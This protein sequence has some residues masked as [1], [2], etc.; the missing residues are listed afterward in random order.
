[1]S[2]PRCSSCDYEFDECVCADDW[3]EPKDAE[4]A[5]LKAEVERLRNPPKYSPEAMLAFTKEDENRA[6]TEALREVLD[7]LMD[8]CMTIARKYM[9]SKDKAE[10]ETAGMASYAQGLIRCRLKRML[11]QLEAE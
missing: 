7:Q 5:T 1:M 3:V 2:G 9:H 4:I 6:K 10:R 11:K 8:D